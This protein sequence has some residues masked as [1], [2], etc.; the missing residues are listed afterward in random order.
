MP[1]TLDLG[2][3]YDITTYAPSVLGGIY[4][5]LKLV[6][7]LGMETATSYRDV[8]SVH[9]E[10]YSLLPNGTLTDP[11]SLIYYRLKDPT[12][13]EIILSQ[14][15]IE[16]ATEITVVEFLINVR[17]AAVGDEITLRNSLSLAGFNDFDIHRV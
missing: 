9:A 14:A 12:N 11:S 6:D 16:T 13:K 7:I 15:W 5:G 3:T 17:N 2:K 8:A 10:I 4:K 1:V